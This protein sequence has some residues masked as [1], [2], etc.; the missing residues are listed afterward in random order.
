MIFKVSRELP[1]PFSKGSEALESE[2][3]SNIFEVNQ[4]MQ[5]EV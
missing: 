1:G 5:L 3:F 2:I 4:A